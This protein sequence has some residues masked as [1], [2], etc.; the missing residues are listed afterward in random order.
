MIWSGNKNSGDLMNGIITLAKADSNVK[1]L[2]V[3]G[4]SIWGKCKEIYLNIPETQVEKTN[5][6]LISI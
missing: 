4:D 5:N 6:F 2:S 1:T 3:E